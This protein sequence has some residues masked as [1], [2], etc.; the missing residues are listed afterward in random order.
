MTAKLHDAPPAFGRACGAA[1]RFGAA[2]K[3]GAAQEIG[4]A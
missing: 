3:G 1:G 4:A 2:Q